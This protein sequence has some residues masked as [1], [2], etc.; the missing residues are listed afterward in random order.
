M[1]SNPP[2]YSN[3]PVYSGVESI[4]SGILIS[5]MREGI[6]TCNYDVPGRCSIWEEAA[7]ISLRKHGANL[8]PHFYQVSMLHEDNRV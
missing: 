7:T 1:F 6:K 3:P 4:L 8:S 5:E 2:A